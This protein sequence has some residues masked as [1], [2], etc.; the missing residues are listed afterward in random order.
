ME[1]KQLTEQTPADR[2]WLWTIGILFVLITLAVIYSDLTPEYTYYQQ[3]FRN[4]VQEN[5]G[6]D[7]AAKVPGGVQQIWNPELGVTD[8]CITCHQG[9]TWSGLTQVKQPY[10]TH[11]KPEL[12]RY[13]PLEEYG[14]TTCHAGQGYATS[15][16]EAHGFDKDW[17]EPLLGAVI[18]EDYLIRDTQALVEIKC[19]ECHRYERRTPG[20]EY[21]NHAKDLIYE[22]SCKACHVINGTGGDIG[23][24]LTYE[25]E[26]TPEEFDFSRVAGFPSVFNW[27]V[28]HFKNPKAISPNTLMPDFN[29]RSRDAQALAMLMMSWTE[30][31]VPVEYIPSVE[32]QD[33]LL[34]EERKKQE[35]MLAGEGKF[36]IDK[37]CF[38]CHSVSAFGIE[39][40]SE[41]GPDLSI[42]VD[43]VV[44]RTGK[45]L[46]E[47][48]NNP[49][50][51]M[52]VV[53]GNYIQLTPEEKA[54]VIEKLRRANEVYKQ[55]QT[56]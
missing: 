1:N 32:L 7:R 46:R 53:L 20:M 12:F 31:D 30:L 18:A 56:Q 39:S 25:G 9:V 5:F 44:E 52:K 54:L 11:P 36:F 10:K 28:E 19:N 17:E 6:E 47:F 13:H 45:H 55:Q 50:G 14:C 29:L 26:K 2:K 48:L 41:K 35:Q 21:I 4:I 51:T 24:A 15:Y 33:E 8:R 22:N 37:G 38:V 43:D 3:Q 40:P 27:Q 34:P 23:P 42:A 49:T 16:W